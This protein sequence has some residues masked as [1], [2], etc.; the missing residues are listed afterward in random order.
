MRALVGSELRKLR[1]TRS[2]WGLLA[3][4]LAMVA[5]GTTSIISE[6]PAEELHKP[7]HEQPLMLMLT[8]TRL[9]VLVLGVKVATDEFRHG[10]AVPTFLATP[11]RCRVV[12][13]KVLAA[14]AAGAVLSSAAVLLSLALAS[15]LLPGQGGELVVTGAGW[16]SLGGL[17]LAGGLW[18]ALGAGV[19]AVVRH[20]VAAVVGPVVWVMFLEETV[21]GPLG[22][23]A[24]YLP[25]RAGTALAVIPSATAAL[26]LASWVAAAWFAASVVTARR[27]V[28]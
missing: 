13:A 27:D 15:G 24:A 25:A 2:S 4:M 28:L 21:S 5:V 23:L 1:T 22:Q 16:R 12:A 11:R 6:S 14:A 7:L 18:A 10:T 20:Q 8:Y 26:I 9:F 3:G 19:G 17:A